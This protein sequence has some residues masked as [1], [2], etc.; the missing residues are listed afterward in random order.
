[1]ESARV[2]QTTEARTGLADVVVG[3][4]QSA[5]TRSNWCPIEEL[6]HGQCRLRNW[7][8]AL[9]QGSHSNM[10][11]CG[12][13]KDTHEDSRVSHLCEMRQLSPKNIGRHVLM[14]KQSWPK[15]FPKEKSLS[16]GATIWFLFIANGKKKNLRYYK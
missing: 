13:F 9:G 14:K 12:V 5:A 10:S 16:R 4:T 7:I 8:I 3:Y 11:W 15:G 1:M 2:I 6:F